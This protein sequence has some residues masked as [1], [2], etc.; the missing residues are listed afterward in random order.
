M[1]GPTPMGC[2][3]LFHCAVYHS[4]TYY[5]NTY[6]YIRA[7]TQMYVYAHQD[8]WLPNPY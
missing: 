3:S 8:T 7:H 6:K 5:M 1:H 4:C 2:I